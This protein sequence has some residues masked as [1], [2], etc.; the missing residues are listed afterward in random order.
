MLDINWIRDYCLSLKGAYEE[1]Q[2]QD[3]LLVKV[4]GKMFI[5]I[6]LESGAENVISIKSNPDEFDE[7]IETEGII[8]APYMARNKWIALQQS[9]KMN[10]KKIKELIKTS[11][12]LVY[13]KLPKKVK[14]EIGN[15]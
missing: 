3:H 5:I 8:P 13:N 1:I 10:P 9:C 4:G 6:S 12:T 7:L 11:Y 14:E 15:L 2:W